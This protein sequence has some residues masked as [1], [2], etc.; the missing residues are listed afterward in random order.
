MKALALVS[1]LAASFACL[2][3][4]ALLS[5]SDH[6]KLA[7]Y[8]YQVQIVHDLLTA[9]CPSFSKSKRAE[10]NDE[11]GADL[12]VQRLSYQKLLQDLIE[13]RSSNGRSTISS[14]SRPNGNF[15]C[16]LE[17]ISPFVLKYFLR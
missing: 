5:R 2:S 14:H 10:I 9:E 1:L 3:H 11:I 17:S 4:A 15:L 8:R 13:C 16:A 12:E 7:L 6:Q